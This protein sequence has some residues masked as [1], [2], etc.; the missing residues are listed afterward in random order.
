[1]S[2]SDNPYRA[3]DAA[4]ID[5]PLD[6]GGSIDATLAGNAVL[7]V[8]EVMR[9]AWERVTGI[10]GIVLA[11]AFTVLLVSFIGTAVLNVVLAPELT[12]LVVTIAM[13]PIFA[14]MF[15][16]G[17][18]QSVGLPVDFSEPFNYFDRIVP[19]AAVGV[20]ASL[21]TAVGMVLL[22]LPGLYLGIA[23]SLSIPL[24]VDKDLSIIDALTTSL[25]LIN[26]KFVSVLVLM[27]IAGVVLVAATFTIVGLVW[28]LPWVV[29]I[30]AITYRQ[31]AGAS[32]SG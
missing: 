32:V 28:A 18:R 31:L 8:Q 13:Y 29:M 26:Q 10:K 17:L 19:I 5:E 23:L 11:G 20:L 30:Y 25:K 1:M 9:E 7:D 22:V 6:T 4:L 15:M 2:D 24:V 12:Q 27:L 21:A 14:G 3:P 16:A